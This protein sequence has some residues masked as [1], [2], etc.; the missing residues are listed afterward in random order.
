MLIRTG[1][2]PPAKIAEAQEKLDDALDEAVLERTL[3]GHVEVEEFT[4]EQASEMMAAAH[5]RWTGCKRKSRES[6]T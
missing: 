6:M 2:L 5:R 4:E 3:Y 1:A